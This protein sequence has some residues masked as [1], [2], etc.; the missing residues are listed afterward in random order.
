MTRLVLFLA[1]RLPPS[2]L[3]ALAVLVAARRA[4]GRLAQVPVVRFQ[5]EFWNVLVLGVVFFLGMPL[6]RLAL[7]LGGRRPLGPR[8][9]ATTFWQPRESA[10]E[11]AKHTEDPF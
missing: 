3:H 5:V 4:P 6:S 2:L 8:A 1:A 10:D 7:A 11:L 9:D